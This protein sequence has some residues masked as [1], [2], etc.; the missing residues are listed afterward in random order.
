MILAQT[1][2]PSPDLNAG[3]FPLIEL[4]RGEVLGVDTL[5]GLGLK[6]DPI[7]KQLRKAEALLAL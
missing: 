4:K 5:E 7:T 2:P 6:V 3:N 1:P